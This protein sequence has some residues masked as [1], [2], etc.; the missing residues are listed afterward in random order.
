MPLAPS[1]MNTD[2]KHPYI[3][4][5]G[6]GMHLPSPVLVVL[7]G[8]NAAT[9]ALD[10]RQFLEKLLDSGE[11]DAVMYATVG[12]T[13]PYENMANIPA[14]GPVSPAIVNG[15]IQ[16][17]Y[18]AGGGARP[19]IVVW[20]DIL[21]PEY[22]RA[23]TLESEIDA[24]GGF[25]AHI[26]SGAPTGME[27]VVQLFW[28]L[29]A[30]EK[31]MGKYQV[32]TLRAF[33]KIDAF[34]RCFLYEDWDEDAQFIGTNKK[35]M[36]YQNLAAN[37][38]VFYAMLAA[39]RDHRWMGEQR[40][41][42]FG[43]CALQ[44]GTKNLERLRH[45]QFS[46]MFFLGGSGDYA[47]DRN[48]LWQRCFSG[49]FVDAMP[50]SSGWDG[51]IER[52][53]RRYA[54][55]RLP[56]M[57]DLAVY[58]ALSG[59]QRKASSEWPREI[60]R[61]F[62]FNAHENDLEA[63]MARDIAAWKEHVI[64]CLHNALD[65]NQLARFLKPDQA[66]YRQLIEVGRSPGTAGRS[67]RAKKLYEI[68]HGMYASH[69]LPDLER[70]IR[71]DR[72]QEVMKRFADL[73]RN[74]WDE[75]NHS[76]DACRRVHAEYGA[77]HSNPSDRRIKHALESIEKLFPRYAQQLELLCDQPELFWKAWR[78]DPDSARV[79]LY[80]GAEKTSHGR[81]DRDAFDHAW[82]AVFQL[83][84]KVAK[85]E[86]PDIFRNASFCE[87]VKREYEEGAALR[88][89]LEEN[90]PRA[91]RRMN[92]A[93]MPRNSSLSSFFADGSFE[94]K[95]WL[96][97]QQDLPVWYG[98][99]IENIARVDL[100]PLLDSLE[101]TAHA[102]IPSLRDNLVE[103]YP[104]GDFP[105]VGGIL[106][107]GE[108]GSAAGGVSVPQTDCPANA[109]DMPAQQ[110]EKPQLGMVQEKYVLHWHWR[111]SVG[112]AQIT[113]TPARGDALPIV[114]NVTRVQYNNGVR[115]GRGAVAGIDVTQYL[116][117]GKNHISIMQDGIEL[118]GDVIGKKRVVGWNLRALMLEV[119]ATGM[120]PDVSKVALCR[121][122]S[123]RDG[124]LIFYPLT[125]NRRGAKQR[126][127]VR[128][129]CWRLP[130]QAERM[131]LEIAPK[132][133]YEDEMDVRKELPQ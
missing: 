29:G 23:S 59:L 111:P 65:L 40:V 78:D 54:E 57:E 46:R 35:E 22:L 107:F 75:V 94:G 58:R 95:K 114:L 87:V 117:Y 129:F 43:T 91:P 39:L 33:A 48:E 88:S 99:D 84:D 105:G 123:V 10:L 68:T 98:N 66:L 69:C 67:V 130:K 41:M 63:R 13:H 8:Q 104:D 74:A 121:K 72:V 103:I 20:A 9:Q 15:T 101:A 45:Y 52:S 7:L 30:Q 120:V 53:I 32:T 106:G 50:G 18:A 76:A 132:R 113:I 131:R 97:E 27:P 26:R 37:E 100:Y 2:S 92:Y 3:A 126:G 102:E 119:Y 79:D 56:S 47:T 49:L 31:G 16:F 89:F 44:D 42:T 109:D 93:G 128:C 71:S 55:R 62:D 118:A 17:L 81:M 86:R 82:R 80:S 115:K 24:L 4:K 1:A 14:D 25:L 21:K 125:P 64:H 19:R 83:C 96:D 38:A 110:S 28:G 70:D 11:T 112:S 6:G 12:A 36:R 122:L 108:D 124:A 5:G 51:L 77:A 34:E 116:A 90:L 60:N 85:N 73:L 127:N 61:L 133:Q